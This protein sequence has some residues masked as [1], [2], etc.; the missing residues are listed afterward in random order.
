MDLITGTTGGKLL[1]VPHDGGFVITW[2]KDI[3][4]DRYDIDV[5]IDIYN[6]TGINHNV[7]KWPAW[8]RSALFKCFSM[9]YFTY[10]VSAC[11]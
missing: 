9:L 2:K 5:D 8:W 11:D 1:L 10:T 3:D 6:T 7:G 4:I